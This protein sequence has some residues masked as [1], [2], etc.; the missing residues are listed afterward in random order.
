MAGGSNSSDSDEIISDINVTPLVD[1]VL[2]LLIVLMVTSSYLVNKS[3]S[4][5]LPKAATG[6]TATPTLSI[7]LD[8]EGKVYLDGEVIEMPALRERIRSAYKAD[9]EVKAIISADGRVTHAQVVSII[10]TLRLEKVTKFAINTSPLE[11][12]EAK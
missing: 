3:I 9:P 12:K 8:V 5:E 1:I 4:V 7:S 2:V 6:E 11:A 10:D